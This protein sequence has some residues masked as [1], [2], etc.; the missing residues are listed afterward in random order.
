MY[1]LSTVPR[2]SS[3]ARALA[4]T[5]LALARPGAVARLAAVALLCTGA[6]RAAETSVPDR[7]WV[8]VS[9]PARVGATVADAF[10][11]ALEVGD[12]GPDGTWI[13]YARDA[14]GRGYRRLGVRDAIGAGEGYWLLQ[15]TGAPVTLALP[16]GAP[17]WTAATSTACSAGRPGWPIAANR[18]PKDPGCPPSSC[19]SAK[20]KSS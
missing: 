15:A 13:V 6:V 3:V 16:A 8:Q 14:A 10:G 20:I 12:Y 17:R 2:R 7:R 5:I 4:A 18:W 1:L 11:R 19:G 9:V